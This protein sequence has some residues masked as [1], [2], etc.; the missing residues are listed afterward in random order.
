MYVLAEGIKKKSAP[1]KFYKQSVQNI[2]Y[3]NKENIYKFRK[4]KIIDGIRYY[5]IKSSLTD[6]PK[7]FQRS[8]LFALRANFQ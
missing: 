8:E 5:W 1:G 7:R 3:F 4:K 6:L 2:S